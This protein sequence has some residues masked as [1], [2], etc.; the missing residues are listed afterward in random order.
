[1]TSKFIFSLGR[2]KANWGTGAIA[3][4]L[5]RFLEFE[6]IH[7]DGWFELQFMIYQLH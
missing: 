4:E 3:N 2:A 5:T 6:D 1:M 7:I